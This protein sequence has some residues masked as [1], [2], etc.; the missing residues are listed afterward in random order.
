MYLGP[1]FGSSTI[2]VPGSRTPPLPVLT[3]CVSVGAVVRGKRGRSLRASH[4]L[5][6]GLE[7]IPL[8]E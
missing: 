3:V 2:S 1:F 6:T 8:L 5:P 4:C 7:T